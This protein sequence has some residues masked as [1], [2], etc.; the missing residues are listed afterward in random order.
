[1]RAFVY[2]DYGSPDVLRLQQIEKPVP[3]ENQVLI[4]VHAASVNPLEW[5]F[6]R[7]IPYVM[8]LE[9]GLRKPKSPRLGT[10]VA[11]EVAAVGKKVTAFKPGDQVFGACDGAFAEYCLGKAKLAMK[12]AS[13][14]YEQ[15]AGV[16]IA[17]ITALQGLRG[18]GHLQA[19]KKVLINGASGGV[20]TFAVQLAKHFG[21]EVTGVCSGRNAEM[22]RGLGA[23]RVIDYKNEDLTNG[24]ERYDLILDCVGTQPL[25]GFR[26]ALKPKGICVLIGGGGPED[27]HWLGPLTRPL[28]AMFI[29]PFVSQKMSMFM[30]DINQDDLQL[31]A[32]LMASGKVKTVIDRTYPFSQAPDALRYVEKGHARGKIVINVQ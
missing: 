4:K 12:P 9:T 2:C 6:L 11:G 3:N 31:L 25:S 13:I 15:A 14:T 8:R 22:V 1:M 21:A 20:G 27:G 16:P 29:A 18:Q 24:A 26:R 23:D 30:A 17:G 32:E 19:G 5:H 7:G 28:Q 10:D